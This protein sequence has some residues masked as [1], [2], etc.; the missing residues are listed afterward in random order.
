MAISKKTGRTYTS[1]RENGY[2]N[3][4]KRP[5]RQKHPK[6]YDRWGQP[7]ICGVVGED[8]EECREPIGEVGYRCDFHREEHERRLQ[9]EGSTDST[10]PGVAV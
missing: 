8:G 4:N 2:R 5:K 1:R 6:G 3:T 10:G 9:A 7:T